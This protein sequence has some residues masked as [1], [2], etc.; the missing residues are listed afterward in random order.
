MFRARG[1]CL[2]QERGVPECERSKFIKIFQICDEDKKGYLSRED[3]KVAITML[4]GY[5]PSK[6]E[7]DSMISL[8]PKTSGVT[9]GE[10]VR[11]MIQK[12]AAQ[13]SIGD[14]RQIFQVFD[15]HCR[16]YLTIEDFKRAFRH[17]AP[18]L[19]EQ[20]VLEAF[21]EVDQDSDGM[22]CYKEFEFAMNYG[23]K[24]E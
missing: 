22:I 3:L 18:H 19:S 16:G 7:V 11:M 13:M 1:L 8:L 10:F 5:K 2:R 20:T 12:K 9:L 6:I 14:E 17:V 21:R 23:E 24:D 4:F 15:A